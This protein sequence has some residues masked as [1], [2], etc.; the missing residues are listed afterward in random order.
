MCKNYFF[1]EKQSQFLWQNLTNNLILVKTITI[2]SNKNIIYYNR[3][4]QF[5]TKENVIL[6]FQNDNFQSRIVKQVFFKPF[7][8]ENKI[9]P[10]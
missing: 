2:F 4:F 1:L 3:L 5:Q 7:F 8:F 10:N 9:K 6:Q